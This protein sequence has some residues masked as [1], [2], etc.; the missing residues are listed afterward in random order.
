MQQE[1]LCFPQP[2]SGRC[3]QYQVAVMTLL[4]VGVMKEIPL[5]RLH[6]NLLDLWPRRRLSR[7]LW[8]DYRDQ[9]EVSGGH[10]DVGTIVCTNYDELLGVDS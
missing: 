7:S 10:E 6:G 5:P 1:V 2:I 4:T 3:L 9:T 8:V